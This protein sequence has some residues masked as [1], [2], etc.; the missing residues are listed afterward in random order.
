MTATHLESK[1]ADASNDPALVE[2]GRVA[3]GLPRRCHRAGRHAGRHM[4]VHPPAPAFTLAYPNTGSCIAT[5]GFITYIHL[6]TT[7]MWQLASRLCYSVQMSPSVFT[8]FD[9]WDH[10]LQQHSPLLTLLQGM[11]PNLVPMLERMNAM[12]SGLGST[13]VDAGAGG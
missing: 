9:M 13:R 12:F 8:R 2:N 10:P 1:R 4:R 7:R 5:C 3:R 6:S 11:Y